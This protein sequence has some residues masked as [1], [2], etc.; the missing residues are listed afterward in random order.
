[1]NNMQ[2]RFMLFLLGCIPLRIIFMLLAKNASNNLLPYL[3]YLALLPAI[4]FTYIYLTGTRTTGP[5]TFGSVIWWNKLRPLHAFLY[6][7]F[8][9]NAI[10]KNQNAWI[11]LLMDIILGL[12]SFLVY[13][14]KNADFSKLI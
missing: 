2:K 3:G 1:M 6:F 9:F 4:G 5:E 10:C 7:L 12:F 8:A 13:H 11:Y 14:Y